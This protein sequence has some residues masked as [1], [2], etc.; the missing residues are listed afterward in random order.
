MCAILALF[1]LIPQSVLADKIPL[2]YTGGTSGASATEGADKLFD[3][4]TSTKWCVLS[5]NGLNCQVSFN[6]ENPMVPEKYRFATCYD[7]DR[8]NSRNPVSWELRGSKD[9]NSWD[10]ISEVSGASLPGENEAY[11]DYF[12]I[13]ANTRSYRY[14]ILNI[15]GIGDSNTMQISEFELYGRPEKPVTTCTL[16]DGM[17]LNA[18]L[19]KLAGTSVNPDVDI[20]DN[21]VQKI[22]FVANSDVKTGTEVS[23]SGSEYK[24]YAQWNS[25]T[26]TITVYTDATTIA[27]NDARY[28]FQYFKAVKVIDIAALNT[29]GCTKFNNMFRYCNSLETLITSNN[30]TI[31]SDATITNMFSDAAS[32]SRKLTITCSHATRKTFHTQ[33]LI[34]SGVAVTWLYSDNVTTTLMAGSDFCKAAKKAAGMDSPDTWKTLTGVEKVKFVPNSY[35]TSEH[36]VSGASSM[37]KAYAK[38][39]GKELQIHTEADTLYLP[40]DFSRGFSYFYD[41]TSYEGWDVVEAKNVRNMSRMFS[42]NNALQTI[43]ISKLNT[44]KVTDMSNIFEFAGLVSFTTSATDRFTTKNV[45]DMSNMFY[46]CQKLTTVDLRN[47][48]TRNVTTMASMF[49]GCTKLSNANLTSTSTTFNTGNVTDMSRMFYYCSSL[50]SVP[51]GATPDVSKVT[52]MS[53]MFSTC[54]SFTSVDLSGWNTSSVTNMFSMFTR[55]SSL[56]GINLSGSFSF[57]EVTTTQ[58]MFSHCTNLKNFTFSEHYNSTKLKTMKAMFYNCNAYMN[59]YTSSTKY[60]INLNPFNTSNVEDMSEM[61]YGCAGMSYFHMDKCDLSS[62]TNMASMFE[63]CTYLNAVTLGK[64]KTGKLTN[65]SKA[66]KGTH[67]WR[68]YDLTNL[69]TELVTDMSGMFQNCYDNYYT[70]NSEITITFGPNFKTS[71][72]TNFSDMF[73]DAKHL[74]TLDISGFNTKSAT[75]MANMF[76]GMENCTSIIT[77]AVFNMSNVT[78][79]TDMLQRSSTSTR[80]ITCTQTVKDAMNVAETAVSNTTWIIIQPLK[81]TL[82]KGSAFNTSLTTLA[83]DKAKITL[84]EFREFD[85]SS[86]GSDVSDGA[87]QPIYAVFDGATGK[88][89]IN[90]IALEF[91]TPADFSNAF[92]GFTGMTEVTGLDKLKTTATTNMQ[93][94]FEGCTAF[95]PSAEDIAKLDVS[96]ATNLQRMFCDCKALTNAPAMPTKVAYQ[97]HKQMFLNC[98]SL[99]T[100]PML[101]A[102]TL[103]DWCYESMFEGCEKLVNAPALPVTKLGRGSYQAMFKGCKSLVDAPAL[104]A[105][106]TNEYSYRYMFQNCSSL[107]TAPALPAT[108]L[109]MHCYAEMFSGCTSLEN[110]PVL[111]AAS[112]PQYSYNKM[113]Y[114]CEK[115]TEVTANFSSYS[116]SNCLTGWLTGTAKNTT[117]VFHANRALVG[118]AKSDY[119]LPSNWTTPDFWVEL[120]DGDAYTQAEDLLWEKV[121]YNRSFATGKWNSWF[122]PFDIT[123]EELA[124]NNMEAAYIAGVRQ[125]ED[126]AM[127]NVKTQV[128]IIKI[129]NARLHPA[130][131]YLVRPSADVETIVLD[132][133][134][135][136]TNVETKHSIHT[137]T[138]L[139]QY[140]FIGTYEEKVPQSGENLYIIAASDGGL[141]PTDSKVWAIDWY[142]KITDKDLP[143]DNIAAASKASTIRINVIGEE[144]Q[145]TGIRTIYDTPEDGG[146]IQFGSDAQVIYDLSGKKLTTPRKGINIV[147]GKKVVIM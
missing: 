145:T 44:E 117:G 134:I 39:V 139:A 130:T 132:H 146:T 60:A 74:K 6:S 119:G 40:A 107:V 125:Y 108:T 113:F 87:G 34:P 109:L 1:C 9:G 66:F 69:D 147:N 101:P 2:T 72:V 53:E 26:K 30:F 112:L 142:M 96:N 22:L 8:Y 118:K 43:D 24:A 98:K 138:A 49:Y 51:L 84:V 102:T 36:V 12:E 95:A 94:M 68:N 50:T 70:L 114:G 75:N 126:D 83:G 104:P 121:T 92:K 61:F 131:P 41:V 16:I 110:A 77:S 89:T 120:N 64:T 63:G 48:D 65:T 33:S 14:Y 99:V 133:N 103:A 47:W 20:D 38:L 111:P 27:L 115:L 100:A 140:D 3:G 35:E 37:I 25:S 76:K 141:H 7:T 46:Y 80:T 129:K 62:L 52:N 71:N 97:G 122:L 5:F 56:E 105:T 19:K 67:Y 116:T 81:A 88:V 55:C 82:A 128:D 11:S 28:A 58:G 15:T 78:D 79:K 13:P 23:A 10:V 42:Y 106:T 32:T 4:N 29:T 143:Y 93:S 54:S 136:L 124:E 18:A 86:V 45:T 17:D 137:E 90:T 127:G 59:Q 21:T 91:Y 73:N 123:T 31:G 57:D 85:E 135:T 144:D